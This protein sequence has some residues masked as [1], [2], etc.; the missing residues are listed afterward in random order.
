M[1]TIINGEEVNIEEKNAID[2]LGICK[3]FFMELL[4]PEMD[5]ECNL[6]TFLNTPQDSKC[7]ICGTP[8]PTTL[9]TVMAMKLEKYLSQRRSNMD[10]KE[11][12]MLLE[13][14]MQSPMVVDKLE[15]QVDDL[16]QKY[17]KVAQQVE[18][19][20]EANW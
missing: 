14:K 5:W 10:E 18:E 1:R 2:E 15:K 13:A 3:T 11:E 16:S 12:I 20:E 19:L 17:G 6:C 4:C 9:P 8:R 7:S